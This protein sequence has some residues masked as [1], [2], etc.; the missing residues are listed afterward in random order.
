MNIPANFCTVFCTV[1]E[2]QNPS[3]PRRGDSEKIGRRGSIEI[4]DFLCAPLR[5]SA[6]A[7]RGFMLDDYGVL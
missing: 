6:S 7:L 1:L 4:L 5:L 3:T 2:N